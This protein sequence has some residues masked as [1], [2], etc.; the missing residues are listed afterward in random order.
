MT[1]TT[2]TPPPVRP[3]RRLRRTRG[4]YAP[5]APAAQRRC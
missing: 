3:R 2:V 5:T 1:T 4:F